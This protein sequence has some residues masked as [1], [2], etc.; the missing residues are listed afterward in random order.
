M[1]KKELHV[2]I[3]HIVRIMD[4][5]MGCF[6][7]DGRFDALVNHPVIESHIEDAG[8]DTQGNG[9]KD[10]CTSGFPAP[11]IFPRY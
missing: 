1:A 10:H 5:Q 7:I 4:L 9:N 6:G 11:D 8:C 2:G 3:G